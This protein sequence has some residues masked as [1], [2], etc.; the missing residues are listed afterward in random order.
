MIGLPT[1]G[2]IFL[3]RTPTDMRKSFDGLG[4]LVRLEHH[5]EPTGGDLFIFVN[6]RRDY[7]KALYWDRD[8]LV[9]W[10]KRLE[11]GHYVMPTGAEVE[12][13]RTSLMMLL[14]GVRA[15]RLKTNRRWI[16]NNACINVNHQHNSP[17]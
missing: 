8:G 7:V 14:E 5:Q 1:Q 11:R 4:G 12:V 9:V 13:D 6:R 16:K 10:S 3:R 15:E 17:S 2:R